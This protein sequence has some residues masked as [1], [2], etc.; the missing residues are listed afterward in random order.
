MKCN[1]NLASLLLSDVFDKCSENCKVF[2]SWRNQGNQ[3]Q[4]ME[5]SSNQTIICL[6]LS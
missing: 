2:P 3:L 5:S 6:S 1:V 4:D